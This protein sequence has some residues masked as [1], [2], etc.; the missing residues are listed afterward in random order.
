MLGPASPLAP[1]LLAASVVPLSATDLALAA[2]LVIGAGVISLA[3]GL[4][5][6]K[7]LG[8]ATLRT[9]IQLLG[10]GYVLT[11]VFRADH[12]ALVGAVLLIMTLAAARAAVG[13]ASRS[14]G[15]VHLHAFVTLLITGTLT[16]GVVTQVVIG[17][18][19]WYQPQYVIPLMGMVFGNA[20]TGISLSLDHLLE[21][22]D[23]RRDHIEARLALGATAWEAAL[24]S[25]REA[26]RR[27]MIPIINAM[28]VAGL[29][30]LPGMMTGQILAGN[31]PLVAVAY[32]IVV[33]FMIAAASALGAMLTAIAVHRRLFDRAHRLRS[34]WILRRET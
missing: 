25:L 8:V 16:T 34:E 17:V 26:I 30:S 13:R 20:L 27:G 18:K 4:G 22:L 3:L 7:R 31:D 23:D 5:L 11:Y 28:S 1:G 21:S 15:G 29:V 33:M 6:E 10:V 19:P 24:P 12:P 9:V 32:Q 14:Y 2:L